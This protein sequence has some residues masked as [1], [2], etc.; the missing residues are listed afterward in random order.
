VPKFAANL[1]MLFGEQPFLDRFAAA[2]A[3]GFGGVEYLF[4]YDFDKAELREQLHQHGLT[5]V[6]HNLPAGNWGPASAASPSCPTG[7]TSFA[8]AS[9]APGTPPDY[10]V[11]QRRSARLT[12]WT[13][14]TERSA[15][16]HYASQ[17]MRL[18][19]KRRSSRSTRSIFP[20][21]LN[22]T[23]RRFSSLQGTLEIC[24]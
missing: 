3:A 19:G 24:S 11:A 22:K 16:R 1:T 15:G 10:R 13:G 17:A 9:R 8:T 21:F 6:L 2:K 4:P 18:P 23:A 5:Q 14:S 12:A 20:V 7:S